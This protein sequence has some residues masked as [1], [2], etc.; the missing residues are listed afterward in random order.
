MLTV[1]VVLID[2]TKKKTLRPDGI[3]ISDFGLIFYQKHNCASQKGPIVG[4]FPYL[5]PEILQ[6]GEAAVTSMSD[7]WAAGC[8]GYELC[9]GRRLPHTRGLGVADIL[10]QHQNDNMEM[11]AREID[12]SE[13]STNVFGGYVLYVIK[14]CLAWDPL[15]RPSAAQMRENVRRYI[16]PALELETRSLLPTRRV[17]EASSSGSGST[18]PTEEEDATLSM[19]RVDSVVYDES[20][21]PDINE[22]SETEQII[23]TDHDS[24]RTNWTTQVQ[25]EDILFDADEMETDEFLWTTGGDPAITHN[26][27]IDTGA[28]GEVHEVHLFQSCTNLLSFMTVV[29]GR[30]TFFLIQITYAYA[31]YRFLQGSLYDHLVRL[32]DNIFKTN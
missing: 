25:K 18:V 22:V 4:S 7:I 32:L 16:D 26:K 21:M 8:I 2:T 23:S 3:H 6:D 15:Q 9:T 29:R 10:Q 11:Y 19:S 27:I 17:S 30:Y 20:N 5:A 28:S 14:R 31:K 13:I 12:L 24:L 1:Y